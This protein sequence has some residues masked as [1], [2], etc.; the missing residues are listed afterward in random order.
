M[1]R[2][3]S[4][5]A[6]QKKCGAGGAEL[7]GLSEFFGMGPYGSH[8]FNLTSLFAPLRF[9]PL[10]APLRFA[11]KGVSSDRS[12]VLNSFTSA[13][14]PT[15]V[16]DLYSS[17]SLLGIARVWACC[18]HSGCGS[19][20]IRAKRVGRDSSPPAANTDRC[21]NKPHQRTKTKWSGG[22]VAQKKC[23]AGGA[24]LLGL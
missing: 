17:T 5:P 22:W 13:T 24:E 8:P 21:K 20:R 6:A 1:S 23:G 15:P 18:V 7:L 19:T 16:N 9:A 3:R 11:P 14:P 2:A 10:L 4:P 12:Q